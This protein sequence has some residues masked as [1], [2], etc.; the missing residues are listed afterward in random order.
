MPTE[1]VKKHAGKAVHGLSAAAIVWM[2]A[3]FVPKRDY[4]RVQRQLDEVTEKLMIARESI[5]S[6][7]GMH[8]RNLE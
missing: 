8:W 5:A 7:Q 1:A 4:D 6:L 3:T 2:Y